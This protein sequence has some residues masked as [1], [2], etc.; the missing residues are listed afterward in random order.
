MQ[1]GMPRPKLLGGALAL[2]LV[3]AGCGNFGIEV[4]TPLPPSGITG[5]VVLG[6]TCPNPPSVGPDGQVPCLT[7]YAAQ[8]VVLDTE[9]KVVTRITSG[10]DGTF[11]VDVPPGDYVIAP[12][13]TASYPSAQPVSVQVVAGNYAQVQI[14]Y[15]TGLR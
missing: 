13:T 7:P 1:V 5:S 4:N 11:R 9:G 2:A 6:P 3:V 8:L 15:D 12:A 10:A 14:N